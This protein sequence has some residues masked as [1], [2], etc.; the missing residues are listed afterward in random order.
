MNT[1]HLQGTHTPQGKA[2]RAVDI[3]VKASDFMLPGTGR[4]HL[5]SGSEGPTCDAHADWYG[6]VFVCMYMRA[7]ACTWTPVGAPVKDLGKSADA[8]WH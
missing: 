8:A 4:V 2:S 7:A 6:E 5:M 3:C 1:S